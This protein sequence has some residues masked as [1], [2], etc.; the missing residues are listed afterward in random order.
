MKEASDNALRKIKDWFHLDVSF[1]NS[2]LEKRRLVISAGLFCTLFLIYFKPFGVTNYDPNFE[3]DLGFVLLMLSIGAAVSIFWAIAEFIIRPKVIKRLT[4]GGLILWLIFVHV[5]ATTVIFIYY[6]LL[7]GWHDM[8]LSS[9]LGF[10]VD[11][12]ALMIFPVSLNLFYFKYSNLKSDHIK[13]SLDVSDQEERKI[14]LESENKKEN[15]YLNSDQL[16]FLESQDNYVAVWFLDKELK[17]RLI[18]STLKKVE[19]S[20]EHPFLIRCHRSFLV[21]LSNVVHV[22]GNNHG[23]ELKI[24][25]VDMSLPVSR[26]YVSAVREKVTALASHPS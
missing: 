23:L 3:V 13:L 17:K 12:A 10:L 7:G 26:N 2:S 22:S 19:A 21:N 24:K 4:N 9:Y 18:R 5:L 8:Y 11:V 20:V 14:F 1:L 15:L 25:S 6:N 16:L